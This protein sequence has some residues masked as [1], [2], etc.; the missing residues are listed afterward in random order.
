MRSPGSLLPMFSFKERGGTSRSFLMPRRVRSCPFRERW[1]TT[2]VGSS[3]ASGGA[4]PSASELTGNHPHQEHGPQTHLSVQH[5]D[6]S[7]RRHSKPAPALHQA[8]QLSVTPGFSLA[9]AP[10]LTRP[11]G[12]GF[13]H[14][15]PTTTSS[16][17]GRATSALTE[18]RGSRLPRSPLTHDGVGQTS[19]GAHDG[20]MIP[21]YVA[22]CGTHI[23]CGVS[24][25]AFWERNTRG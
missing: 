16:H 9:A 17:D 8:V 24:P 13:P 1:K 18:K 14:H 21:R 10:A 4:P 7:G 25:P 15:A 22:D 20:F 11:A 5:R 3:R 12:W 23:R 19:S 6:G 2:G